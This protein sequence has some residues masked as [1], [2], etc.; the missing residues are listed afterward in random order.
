[1]LVNLVAF[2]SLLT[3]VPDLPV[4]DTPFCHVHYL[5]GATS[6]LA[7]LNS[8]LH[9]Q[10]L[11]RHGS[12]D[13]PAPATEATTGRRRGVLLYYSK[14]GAMRALP[15]GVV[16]LVGGYLGVSPLDIPPLPYRAVWYSVLGPDE[17][18]EE[19]LSDYAQ[20]SKSTDVSY[21]PVYDP[22]SP[23]R[24]TI[25]VSYLRPMSP[26]GP[27]PAEEYRAFSDIQSTRNHVASVRQVGRV[28]FIAHFP[29]LSNLKLDNFAREIEQER[30]DWRFSIQPAGLPR[31]KLAELVARIRKFAA[32]RLQ[33]RDDESNSVYRTRTLG[34]SWLLDVLQLVATD[35][36]SVSIEASNILNKQQPLSVRLTVQSKKGT[37]RRILGAMAPRLQRVPHFARAESGKK[38]GGLSYAGQLPE[39]LQKSLLKLVGTLENE[40]LRDSWRAFLEENQVPATIELVQRDGHFVIVGAVTCQ[41]AAEIVKA[42]RSRD[43]TDPIVTMR[44]RGE[45]HVAPKAGLI[46]RG[47]SQIAFTSMG[48]RLV[49]AL[50][51]DQVE[52]TL[53]SASS[54]LLRRSRN[55]FV[56]CDLDL[57]S[58]SR[59]KRDKGFNGWPAALLDLVEEQAFRLGVLRSNKHVMKS[60]T[61]L[62]IAIED[63]LP[64]EKINP[65][66][67][68]VIEE[69]QRRNNPT[70]DTSKTR[71]AVL[72]DGKSV[73]HV[74]VSSTPTSL[75]VNLEVGR[76]AYRFL[77]GQFFEADRN[78]QEA[79]TFIK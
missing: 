61:S 55:V 57:S 65:H 11:V 44:L 56:E 20:R 7:T 25:R 54:R 30:L 75:S 58:L 51:D 27:K 79:S 39:T 33:R 38:I 70:F 2:V 69:Y 77:V 41:Q 71:R 76:G 42:L 22:E 8:K 3:P 53:R 26:L 17:S 16:P 14:D 72:A 19:W 35:V 15:T 48:N 1:M 37:V 45:E 40:T 78:L 46:P 24:A 31:Q 62:M 73:F 64:S 12:V 23:K 60:L 29:A 43:Q 21:C 4:H 34:R 67:L 50:G 66:Y 49:F 52:D 10:A 68:K 59:A 6:H 47:P 18:L 13:E 63:S 74:K 28:V 5:E 36:K 9:F 32:P